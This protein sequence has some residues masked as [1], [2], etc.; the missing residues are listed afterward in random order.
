MSTSAFIEISDIVESNRSKRS[1]INWTEVVGNLT[2]NYRLLQQLPFR[3]ECYVFLQ[4]IF[5][6]DTV[7][8][9][10]LCKILRIA[11]NL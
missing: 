1:E 9:Y 3:V 10:A 8:P 7:M 11:M 6:M 4:E 2:P 5:F